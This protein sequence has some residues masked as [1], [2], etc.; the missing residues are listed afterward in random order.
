MPSLRGGVA[1]LAAGKATL[2][3]A[4]RSGRRGLRSRLGA[5]LWRLCAGG[6]GER[7]GALSR[8]GERGAV[9]P[10]AASGGEQKVT[11]R[12]PHRGVSHQPPRVLGRTFLLSPA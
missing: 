7:Q 12:S 4:P 11:L 3:V 6:R 2:C 10:P 1:P 9:G 5:A 8:A